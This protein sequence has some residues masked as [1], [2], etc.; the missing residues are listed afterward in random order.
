[1]IVAMDVKHDKPSVTLLKP[2]QDLS[3]HRI[4][5]VVYGKRPFDYVGWRALLP[6]L[7][8]PCL[9][10]RKIDRG[11]ARTVEIDFETRAVERDTVGNVPCDELGKRVLLAQPLFGGDRD[12]TFYVG[13]NCVS[14]VNGCGQHGRVT[15]MNRP[16]VGGADLEQQLFI[17]GAVDIE[18]RSH[19]EFSVSKFHI[20][21]DVTPDEIS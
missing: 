12:D 21:T 3:E 4:V 19:S 15:A 2:A 14:V 7:Q 1:M 11:V 8:T 17:A 9:L 13:T 18:R 10:C 16:Q 6:D 20:R 5:L